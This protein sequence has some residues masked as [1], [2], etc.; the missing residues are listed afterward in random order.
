V[1]ETT[2]RQVLYALV[3]AGFHLVVGVLI[4]GAASAGL[5]PSWWTAL[6]AAAWGTVALAAGLRW[7]RT[8]LVLGLTIGM[9][10]AWT[11]GT[12]VVR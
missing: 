1:S 10:V 6:T 9:F 11:V 2:P 7:R 12:L 3:G 8:P 5:V 4:A